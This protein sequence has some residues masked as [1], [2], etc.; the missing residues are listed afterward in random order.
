VRVVVCDFA[1]GSGKKMSVELDGV[2]I[3]IIT[4]NKIFKQVYEKN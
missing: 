3:D 4:D 1:L 2:L